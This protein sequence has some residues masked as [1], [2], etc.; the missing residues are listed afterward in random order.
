MTGGPVRV[1]EAGEWL[2]HAI[3]S[4]S[5]WA[6]PTA[7]SRTSTRRAASGRRPISATSRCRSSLPPPRRRRGRCCRRSSTCRAS[8]SCPRRGPSALERRRRSDRGRIRPDPGCPVPSRLVSS[9]KSWLCHPGI[10]READILPWGSPPEIKKISPVGRVGRVPAAHPRRVERHLRR[11]R[12]RAAAGGPGGRA[13]R[14]G[15]VRRGRAR[16]DAP[17]RPRGPAGEHHAARGAAGGVLLL[18]RLA[19]GSVAARGPRR[20][21]DPRL[22][23]RRRHHGF[24]PD[25]GRRDGHRTGVPPCGG[26]RSPDARRRQ[27]RPGAAHHVEKKLGGRGWTPSSGAP[28]GSPA[29]RPRRS[30]WAISSRLSNTGR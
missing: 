1:S 27:H 14:P 8:M 5:T 6:R 9:A 13:H 21:A 10:D 7:R 18:D 17:G 23:H 3:S 11:G 4:V 19:Q 30:C 2:G 12:R 15:L 22:R 28:C 26:R 29:G 20:R 24:Q 16:A 25:H